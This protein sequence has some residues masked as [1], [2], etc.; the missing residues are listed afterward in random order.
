MIA[1]G[2]V[3]ELFQTPAGVV[4]AGT[5]AGDHLAAEGR[6]AGRRRS[7]ARR[8]CSGVLVNRCDR[9][10]ASAV[11][12]VKRLLHGAGDARR[13]SAR[14]FDGARP[15]R[16]IVSRLGSL[17][18]R[19]GLTCSAVAVDRRRRSWWRC[20][21]RSA[22]RRAGA[23]RQSEGAVR[24]DDLVDAPHCAARPIR[25]AS[26]PCRATFPVAQRP[27][28]G[29]VAAPGAQRRD[30]TG[31]LTAREAGTD[32]LTGPL[33]TTRRRSQSTPSTPATR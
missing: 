16:R 8:R 32:V 18:P 20:W 3:D 15:G 31:D 24:V 12:A 27:W 26:S 29:G 6:R 25:P 14:G 30:P 11:A 1:A 10:G 22:R 5:L 13:R 7:L 17:A 4:V 2:A 33:A 19:S 28:T 9:H 21:D 23:A